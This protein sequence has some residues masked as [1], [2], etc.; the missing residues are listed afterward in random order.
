MKSLET[1]NGSLRQKI[2]L[3][4]K[5]TRGAQ[6]P[7]VSDENQKFSLK[8]PW[9]S[10]WNIQKFPWKIMRFPLTNPMV[11]QESNGLPWHIQWLLPKNKN[12]TV[13]FSKFNGFLTNIEWFPWK[14]SRFPLKN[15]IVSIENSNRFPSKNPMVSHEK[16]NPMAPFENPMV[17]LEHS[18][19]G[20][21][22]S[23]YCLSK[24]TWISFKNPTVSGKN[25]TVSFENLMVSLEKSNGSHWKN[26]LASLHRFQSF[27]R[28]I[29]WFPLKTQWFPMGRKIPPCPAK[30]PWFPLKI[31]MFPH[32]RSVG[33]T[34][35]ITRFALTNPMVSLE[36]L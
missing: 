4:W 2:S 33:F 9:V 25:P 15:P 32:E 6:N 16:Q 5:S 22:R 28:K 10:A 21:E 8:Q 17:S 29:S 20:H 12:H 19:F 13:S 1:F 24:I 14:Q 27:L 36:N 30:I 7:I 3:S 31:H 34:S 35:K 26:P 18:W 11:S 23:N